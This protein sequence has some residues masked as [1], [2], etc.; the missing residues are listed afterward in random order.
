MTDLK[1]FA[2]LQS[3]IGNRIS[4]CRSHATHQNPTFYVGDQASRKS[5][6]GLCHPMLFAPTNEGSGTQYY[7]FPFGVNACIP[8][9]SRPKIK[10]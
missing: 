8:V 4:N 1:Y 10:P 5:L 3:D 2:Y 9:I 6:W 7:S